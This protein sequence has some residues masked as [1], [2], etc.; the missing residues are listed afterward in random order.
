MWSS[1]HGNLSSSLSRTSLVNFDRVKGVGPFPKRRKDLEDSRISLWPV[2][3]PACGVKR[4]S[5][6]GREVPQYV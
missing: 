3:L 6:G 2:L 1:P 4:E 5:D